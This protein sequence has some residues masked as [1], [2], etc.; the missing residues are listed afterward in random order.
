[1]PHLHNFFRLSKTL[2]SFA[3]ALLVQKLGLLKQEIHF[4]IFQLE[5]WPDSTLGSPGLP[6]F[7]LSYQFTLSGA[8]LPAAYPPPPGRPVRSHSGLARAMLASVVHELRFTFSWITQILDPTVWLDGAR[9]ANTCILPSIPWMAPEHWVAC[10]PLKGLA[11]R[12]C[13]AGCGRLSRDG[14]WDTDLCTDILAFWIK[15]IQWKPRL[16]DEAKRKNTDFK[17]YSIWPGLRLK[18]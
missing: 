10:Q 3:L 9:P 16:V 4:S 11:P 14:G 7:L 6:P 18:N 13:C 1:M 15:L 5:P 8:T 17:F 2:S 12:V